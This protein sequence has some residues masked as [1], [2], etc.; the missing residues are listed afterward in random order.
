M[1]VVRQGPG[2]QEVLDRAGREGGDRWRDG[3][4]VCRWDGEGGRQLLDAC[5][6]RIRWEAC[7][8]RSYSGLVSYPCA[9]L[10]PFGKPWT[11]SLAL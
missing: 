1:L 7:F 10:K 3:C 6:W 11:R 4:A 5:G 2:R 9:W 8:L